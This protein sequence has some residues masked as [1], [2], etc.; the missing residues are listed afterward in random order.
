MEVNHSSASHFTD[1]EEE[2]E[3]HDTWDTKRALKLAAH[4]TVD[5]IQLSN[6]ISQINSDG[7]SRTGDFEDSHPNVYI[8]DY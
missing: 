5:N 6:S 3:F 1:N 4:S 8:A 2:V 7:Q